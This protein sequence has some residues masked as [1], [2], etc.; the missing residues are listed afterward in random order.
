MKTQLWM[1]LALVLVP[2]VLAARTAVPGTVNYI[3]G[4]VSVDGRQMA[5]SQDGSVA[6]GPNQTLSVDS[7]KAEVLLSPGTFLRVGNNSQIR[8]V[9][10]TLSDPSVELVRGEAMVEVDYKPK[11]ARLNVMERGANAELLKEGL[12][13]FDADEAKVEVIDGKAA[14]TN[15]GQSRDIGKGKE[16]VLSGAAL[17]P[18]SFDRKADDDLYRWSDVRASYLAQANEAS[19]RTVYVGGG[20]GWGWGPGWFWNPYFA[21]YSWL[22]GDGFFWS[23][24]GYPFFSPGYVM[25]APMIRP[26]FYA[27]GVH[28]VAPTGRGSVAALHAAGPGRLSGVPSPGFRSMAA[29][30]HLSGGFGGGFH[31]GGFHGGGGRR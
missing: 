4:Q 26:R 15:N 5:T 9:S 8:M 10:P 25:Y 21:T 24:F 18:V 13:R 17:K 28:G 16:L 23:P 1:A 30:P 2:G 6:L 27:G 7:G 22:P 29:T 31:G 3:E 19:A 20:W 11:Q 12:Y 14:V